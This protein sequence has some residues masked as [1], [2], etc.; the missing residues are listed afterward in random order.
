MHILKEP[1]EFEWD[2]G[3]KDKNW[4]K[5]KVSVEEIEEAVLSE[6][7]K[8]AKDFFHSKK[9]NRYLLIGETKKQRILFI[10]FTLRK[11]KIRVISAR[12]LNKQ[13]ERRLY[14]KTTQTTKV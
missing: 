3:N 11:N 13:R 1:V 7:K 6:S 14:E 4:Q 9:E 2:R 8:I 5:H 12:D 10:V